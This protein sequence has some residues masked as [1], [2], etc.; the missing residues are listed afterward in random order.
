MKKNKYIVIIL[1]THEFKYV[2]VHPFTFRRTES[3]MYLNAG[4]RYG[5][6]GRKTAKRFLTR[7]LENGG[8]AELMKR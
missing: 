2:T 8:K 1:L 5:F 7:I 4:T 6:I 3:I